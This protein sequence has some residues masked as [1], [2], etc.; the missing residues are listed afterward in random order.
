MAPGEGNIQESPEGLL[1]KY[2]ERLQSLAC[3]FDVCMQINSTLELEEV[4]GNIMTTSREVMGADACSLML[5]DEE[6]Q[7]LVFEVAQGAVGHKLKDAFKVK[8]GEGI[9]GYV[10]ETGTP[11]IV[12]DA[13]KDPRF[14][15]EFDLKTG[16]RTQSVLCVPLKVK[17]RIVG[18]SQVINKL[19]GT[20]FTQED[21]ETFSL[22]SAQAG[23]AID[24]ARV[25]RALLRKQQ[26]E[27]DLAFATTVQRSFLPQTVPEIKR[28]CFQAHNQ[29]ALEVGGDFYDFIPLPGGRLGILVGDVSGKGV[30][31]ALYMARLTS[32]LRLYATHQRGAARAVEQLNDVL[33]ERSRGGMFVTL[34]YMVLNPAK[35]MITYVNAGHLPPL[36]WNEKESR[37]C[38]FEKGA[39]P[40]LGILPGR[41]YLSGRI[42]LSP[43]DC[44]LL[45]TDGLVEARDPQGRQFGWER[46]KKAMR[47]GD[48]RAEEV[49]HRVMNTMTA[50]A[51]GSSQSDDITLVVLGMEGR[52]C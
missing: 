30:S 44:L 28:F 16:Y 50:F 40:P 25:H 32:D 2:E 38:S 3:C 51:R 34:I 17:G 15:Q 12:E 49:F 11:L 6:T 10:F 9:A 37:V 22:L 27:S 33:C 36:L 14:C 35:Q 24:N 1:R 52:S 19:D 46:L 29:A 41:R 31:S 13:Y 18:V 39:G 26:I 20:A 5:A 45:A 43:G 42:Q 47:G 21:Q 48:S 8:K 23:I 7:E 4:L